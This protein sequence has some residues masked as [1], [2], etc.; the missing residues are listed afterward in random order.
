M[1][2]P[3]WIG[4]TKDGKMI[5]GAANMAR[6]DIVS[7]EQVY[8]S[9]LPHRVVALTPGGYKIMTPSDAEGYHISDWGEVPAYR[10]YAQHEEVA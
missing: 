2:Y 9:Q 3:I 8:G 6:H 1:T 10:R 7:L 4:A 5:I